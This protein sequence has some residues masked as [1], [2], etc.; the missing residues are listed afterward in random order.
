MS[1]V[2]AVDIGG[3]TFAAAAIGADRGMIA[4]VEVPI[5]TDPTATLATLIGGFA[6]DGLIGVGIGS[7]GPLDPASGSVSPVN[8]PAWRRYPIAAAVA[9]LTGL[10][11]GLAG[12]AQCMALGEYWHRAA[13]PSMLGLVVSTGI[14]GG[15]VL[16]GEPYFGRS[17]NAGHIGHISID[18]A[19][20]RC[21][22]G[23][24][25]CVETVASGPSMTAYAR[26]RGWTGPDARALSTDASAGNPVA[27]LA[28]ARGA[29]ALAT[30]ILTTAALVDIDTVVV[31]GGVA[32]AGE[33][34]FGPLRQAL[35]EQA[36]LGFL[37][38][39]TVTP[40]TLARDAG[41]YGAA[42]LAFALAGVPV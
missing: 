20:A 36:G 9:D 17:G 33:V 30:A 38:H 6:P 26:S 42:A 16:D 4:R 40:T 34:L 14:G 28:F 31:G 25:G 8:I 11:V 12:D 1:A 15:L 3:T 2:L 7:A 37:Q 13:A 18:P 32:A 22:C 10:P 24:T 19:G 29:A 27:R 39:V 35:A 21:P 5:G 23:G 41:L